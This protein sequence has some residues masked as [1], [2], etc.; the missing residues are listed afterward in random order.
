[1]RIATLLTAIVLGAAAFASALRAQ[2][3]RADIEAVVR[4]YLAAHPDEVGGIVKDY[5]IKHP[6]AVG[7]IL[8]E[9]LKRRPG[10]RKA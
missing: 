3:S 2:E 10:G 8:A 7:Q 6:E 4:D 5:F 1:M 9:L